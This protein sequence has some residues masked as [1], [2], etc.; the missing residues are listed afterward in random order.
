M[1]R[2]VS[3]KNW[4]ESKGITQKVVA[5]GIGV[6]VQYVSAIERG[7]RRPGMRVALAIR[8]FTSGEVLMHAYMN[9]EAFR[10]TIE[11]G[12]AVYWSRSRKQLWHKGATSG[13][14]QIYSWVA[15]ED[16]RHPYRPP[17]EP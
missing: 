12:E 4:R 11:L 9:A 15:M 1:S 6:H 16:R 5:A 7:V 17:D 8:D 3:L 14:V 10:K 2:C 13:L